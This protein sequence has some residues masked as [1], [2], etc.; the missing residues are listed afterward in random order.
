M[1]RSTCF[2]S[3]IAAV[4]YA[5]F[6]SNIHV[7][8]GK[9]PLKIYV[10]NNSFMHTGEHRF[11]PWCSCFLA[12]ARHKSQMSST[13]L[14]PDYYLPTCILEVVVR[15]HMPAFWLSDSF[16][17]IRWKK[18]LCKNPSPKQNKTKQS[19]VMSKRTSAPCGKAHAESVITTA[20][21]VGTGEKHP[22]R[23]SPWAD[24]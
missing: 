11:Q 19:K 4:T 6:P 8:L 24:Q 18:D 9:C 2:G 15:G 16:Q 10:K 3:P 17:S 1:K 23:P 21:K 14:F 13:P 7:M 20:L 12:I 5:F 22:V